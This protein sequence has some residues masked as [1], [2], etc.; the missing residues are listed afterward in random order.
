MSKDFDSCG[1]YSKNK[2]VN[3][4]AFVFSRVSVPRAKA[5]T[6]NSDKH[7][8]STTTSNRFEILQNSEV[9]Q[10]SAPILLGVEKKNSLNLR[11]SKK[12]KKKGKKFTYNPNPTGDIWDQSTF[13]LDNL[14]KTKPCEY[15]RFGVWNAESVRNKETLVRQYITENELDVL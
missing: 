4:N 9:S 6:N 5:C 10:F 2:N 11:N 1:V 3:D 7:V 13:N 15:L 8:C 14:F 12:L